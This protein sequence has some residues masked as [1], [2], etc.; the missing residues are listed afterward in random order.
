[1][2]RKILLG[3]S[4]STVILILVAVSCSLSSR[5]ND[6]K[7]ILHNINSNNKDFRVPEVNVTDYVN[8]VHYDRLFKIEDISVLVEG[9][10]N[11]ITSISKEQ[12]IEDINFLFDILRNNY[13]LYTY[14]GGNSK[15]LSAK[16]NIIKR[17]DSNIISK[18]DFYNVLIE[19]LNFINDNHFSL[20]YNSQDARKLGDKSYFYILDK[21]E[22]YKDDSGFFINEKNK[23]KYIVSI[24][25]DSYV[26]KYMNL[27]VSDKG[28]IIYKV[29]TLLTPDNDRES[30][31]EKASFDI[32][33]SYEFEN[34]IV[35]DK[36]TLIRANYLLNSNETFS[37]DVDNDIPILSLRSFSLDEDKKNK[38]LQSAF[39]LKK[40]KVNILDLRGN[41][42]GDGTLVVEWLENRFGFRPVGNSKKIGLN[43]FLFNGELPSEEDFV[44][45][46][47]L[48][49]LEFK[50]DYYY[51]KDID[52]EELYDNNSLIFILTDINQGS[53]GEM[54]IEYIK[55]YEN[56]ILVGTNTSGTIQ[57]GSYGIDFK[58]PNSEIHFD[59]GQWLYLYDKEYFRES[60]GY[61]PDIWVNGNDALEKTLALIK[62]Y[63]LN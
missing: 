42:G 3:V 57:G 17:I 28:E 1:M 31:R 9:K 50:D 38:F 22:Y 58:L 55:N 37:I 20:N 21:E 8:D 44:G 35:T 23:K 26:E 61:K 39:E 4:V 45:G 56:V 19:R 60:V 29:G 63:N 41:G 46:N 32:N 11:N 2:R 53:A 49:N 40:Y 16:E 62:Y 43:R 10:D 48:F 34:N 7:E 15:F 59:F 24:N 47:N 27:S 54:F 52:K 12:A 18:S 51:S 30:I 33:I 36:K 13:G 14:L 6:F 25:D 5:K